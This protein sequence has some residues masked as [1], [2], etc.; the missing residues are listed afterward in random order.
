MRIGILGTRGIPNNYGGFE[1]FA[2]SFAVYLTTKGHDVFVY[3]SSTH[4]YQKSIF[5]GVNIIHKYDPENRIGTIGQFVYDALCILDTRKHNFDVVLQLGYTSSSIFSFLFPTKIKII[6]NM[7]GLEWKRSKYSKPV[8]KFLRYAENLAVKNSH[9]LISDSIGIKNYLY[10]KYKVT[11]EYIAYGAK[12]FLD[13]SEIVLESYGLEKHNYNILIARLEPENNIETIIKAT[14]KSTNKTKLVIIGNHQNKF[15]KYLYEKYASESI[16]FLGAIYNH[17]TL[18][19]LRYFSNLYFH[20]HSVGGT[21][22][23][24][25]EAI[26]C[27]CFIVAHDNIFNRGILEENAM[28]FDSVNALLNIINKGFRKADVDSLLNNN[29][30]KIRTNLSLESINKQTEEFILNCI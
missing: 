17:D 9:F 24:L 28:F 20:G 14:I 8:Q 16:L 21:N 30:V 22:P 2:E 25:I 19:N 10:E 23:S 26:A 27:S 5:K 12:E 7:D 13:S 1:Q 4:S 6:T 18:N 29:L 15:G 11:S 3:N